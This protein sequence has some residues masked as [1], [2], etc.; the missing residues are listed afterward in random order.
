MSIRNWYDKHAPWVAAALFSA[1]FVAIAFSYG[2]SKGY[3]RASQDHYADRSAYEIAEKAYRSVPNDL[4]LKKPLA[5]L[6][7]PRKL[8]ATIIVPSKT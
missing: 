1:I 2:T 3:H 8:P 4:P 6:R 5:A 7:R